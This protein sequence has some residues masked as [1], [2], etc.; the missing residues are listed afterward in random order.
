M[1][2]TC[3]FS[4]SFFCTLF[5]LSLT[6]NLSANTNVVGKSTTIKA[7]DLT[8][9]TKRSIKDEVFY[10]VLP[11]RFNNGDTSNDQGA[12]KGDVTRALSRGGFDPT[13]N[14]GYHGGDLIGLTQKL[15]YLEAMGI[16]AQRIKELELI[17]N[18]VE[19]PLGGAHRD[20]ELMAAQLKQALK[21]DLADLEGL[22][23]EQ[24]I[25]KR[26]DRLMSFGYC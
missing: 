5:S 23:K 20:M 9:Y 26:Y 10:F 25:E 14:G 1:K 16:T 11:D 7:S 4:I 3:A 15:P 22:T 19:E 24:L 2:K 13:S 12:K 21:S 8:H 6:F 17:D 18:I